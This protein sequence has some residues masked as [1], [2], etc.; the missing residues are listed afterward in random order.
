[1]VRIGSEAGLMGL[2]RSRLW[3]GSLAFE[4]SN[5]TKD[6]LQRLE[7]GAVAVGLIFP[8]MDRAVS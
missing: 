1:M 2:C 8:A 3:F 7:F 5:S 4:H 6:R